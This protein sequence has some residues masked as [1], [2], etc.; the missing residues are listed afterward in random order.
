MSIHVSDKF[1]WLEHVQLAVNFFFQ[2]WMDVFKKQFLCNHQK[3]INR[4]H[5]F[6]FVGGVDVVLLNQWV[7]YK[8][9]D[10]LSFL[11]TISSEKKQLLLVKISY[12]MLL[13]FIIH[14]WFL[15]DIFYRQR[16]NEQFYF[17][18]LWENNESNYKFII[19]NITHAFLNYNV[20][21]SHFF[22]K[23]LMNN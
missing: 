3:L 13:L 21:S 9:F 17:C 2:R 14:S 8:S 7:T 15:Y 4:I 20:S 12:Y 11:S 18:L 6:I 23:K 22:Q 10:L 5:N 16:L 1:Q 19:Q